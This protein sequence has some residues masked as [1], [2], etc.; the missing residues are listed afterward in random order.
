MLVEVK[1]YPLHNFQ[2]EAVWQDELENVLR[3]HNATLSSD[4]REQLDK[5]WYVWLD[6]SVVIH[7]QPQDLDKV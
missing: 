4:Q 3:E 1:K 2:V 6:G 7:K 5:G